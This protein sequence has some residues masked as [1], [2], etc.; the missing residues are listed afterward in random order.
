MSQAA[1]L[2]LQTLARGQ[3]ASIAHRSGRV[4]YSA[5]DTL[6]PGAIYV[7]GLN[8][9]GRPDR[10]LGTVGEAIESLTTQSGNAYLD[11]SWKGCAPGAAPIQRRVRWLLEALG[12]NPRAVCASNL[13]FLRS[14]DASGCEYPQAADLCRPVHAAILSIVQPRLILAFGHSRISPFAYLKHICQPPSIESVA[15]GHGTWQCLG[16]TAREGIRVVGLPHLSR[17]AV[18][19][20]P[21]VAAWVRAT[22]GL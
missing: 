8:P 20:Y 9:G 19:R 6:R 15:A 7:L 11:E 4:L 3:L 22:A 17:Y 21:H 14:R 5:T 13:I 18:D 1:A 16:F 12:Q 2:A 10:P